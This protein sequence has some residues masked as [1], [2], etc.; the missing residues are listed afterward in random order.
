M[1]S[2]A[3]VKDAFLLCAVLWEPPA[4]PTNT[5]MDVGY[6]VGSAAS[7]P[8]AFKLILHTLVL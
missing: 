6:G 1:V 2:H 3:G 5:A 8:K 7:T 4:R